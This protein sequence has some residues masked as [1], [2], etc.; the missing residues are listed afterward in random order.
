MPENI[1]VTLKTEKPGGFWP[2]VRGVF[3][4]IGFG[5]V[6]AAGLSLLDSDNPSPRH[7]IE[8]LRAGLQAYRDVNENPYAG[9]ALDPRP[10]PEADPFEGLEAR[11]EPDMHVVLP[12][13]TPACGR[14]DD[15]PGCALLGDPANGSP[16]HR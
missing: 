14:Y 11:P 8:A 7:T 13:P 4:C 12:S 9:I 16:S 3:A 2:F 6:V 1:V 15:R 5:V 10:A